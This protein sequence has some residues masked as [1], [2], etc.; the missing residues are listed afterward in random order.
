[1]LMWGLD[2]ILKTFYHMCSEVWFSFL[3]RCVHWD[4]LDRTVIQFGGFLTQTKIELFQEA[5]LVGTRHNILYIH[6]NPSF[7]IKGV[8]YIWSIT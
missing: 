2:E 1:M 6:T 4:E 8:A 5:L 7:L 3:L